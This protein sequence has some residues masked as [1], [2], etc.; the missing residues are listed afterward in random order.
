MPT[1]NKDEKDVK[2]T[3]TERDVDAALELFIH[4][5]VYAGKVTYDDCFSQ[6][7]SR[8]CLDL[9]QAKMNFDAKK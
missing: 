6:L 7:T 4:R 3:K 8:Q 2:L 1:S 5:L 9:R